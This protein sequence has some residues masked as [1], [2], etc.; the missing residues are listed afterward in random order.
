MLVG[1]IGGMLVAIL[2][3]ATMLRKDVALN[4]VL[5]VRC[6]VKRV[7]KPV[8]R[9]ISF[10][11]SAR[12]TR[13]D[14]RHLK[15]V[16]NGPSR[17]ARNVSRSARVSNGSPVRL[18]GM[19]FACKSRGSGH[20]VGKLSLSVPTKGAATVINLDNDKGA[21]LVGLVLKFCPPVKKTIV[22][23]GRSLRGVDFGR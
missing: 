9:F 1:R 6:V 12:S 5:S 21:A 11:R 19:I 23:N 10:V 13:L 16:R 8:D 17:R 22:V 7:R 20:V 14:L 18:R 4:I 2:S 3:T 15:R